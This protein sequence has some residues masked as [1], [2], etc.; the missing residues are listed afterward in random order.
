MGN[1]VGRVSGYQ[2]GL[3]AAFLTY[4]G[5][6]GGHPSKD[7]IGSGLSFGLSWM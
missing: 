7:V 1:A 4:G 5:G 2:T 6:R 3:D